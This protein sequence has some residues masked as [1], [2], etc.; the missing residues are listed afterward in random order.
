M[1]TF[2][3]DSNGDEWHDVMCILFIWSSNS[4]INHSAFNC[5]HRSKAT[6]ARKEEMG[7]VT[8]G[9][10][11]AKENSVDCA[12]NFLWALYQMDM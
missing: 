6:A 7:E 4:I 9:L 1:F 10:V 3:L 5:D 8:A 2:H 12:H 11:A